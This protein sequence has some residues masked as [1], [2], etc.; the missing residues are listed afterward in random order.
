MT[1]EII[2]AEEKEILELLKQVIDP[3]LMVNIVDLGLV[4]GVQMSSKTKAIIISLTLT[5]VGCPMGDVIMIDIENTL[6]RQYPNYEIT[7]Q[8]VWNPKWNPD[9]ASEEGQLALTEF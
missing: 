3:E 4:Y 2:S 5:S 7:V 1:L 9:M 8:L 6:M